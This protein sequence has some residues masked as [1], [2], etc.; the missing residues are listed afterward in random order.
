MGKEKWSASGCELYTVQYRDHA[1]CRPCLIADAKTGDL[2]TG[3]L[4]AWVT[5]SEQYPQLKDKQE[6]KA[7]YGEEKELRVIEEPLEECMVPKNVV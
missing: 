2:K 5:R 1:G 4:K 3:G 7:G 6:T